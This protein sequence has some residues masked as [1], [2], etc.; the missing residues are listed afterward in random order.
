MLVTA[1]AIFVVVE[2]ARGDRAWAH[3]KRELERKGERLDFASFQPKSVPPDENFLKEPALALLLYK[4]S[5]DS[6]RQQLL[7]DTRLLE[8]DALG[9]Y[10][11]KNLSGVRDDLVRAGLLKRTP[12]NAPASDVLDALQP[13]NPLLDV[14]VEA[15]RLR[16]L[17]AF[18]PRPAPLEGPQLEVDLI[19][20]VSVA[21]SVR[22]AVYLELGRIHHAESDISAVQRLGNAFSDNPET[23]LNLLVGVSAQGLAAGAVLDG[24]RRHCWTEAQ[25]LVFERS[26]NQVKPLAG[27][28]HAMQAERAQV[29]YIIDLRPSLRANNFFWPWWMFH[30]WAQQNKIVYCQELQ[31]RVFNRFSGNLD[32]ITR[33]QLLGSAAPSGFPLYGW[34]SRLALSNYEKVLDGFGKSV[35]TLRLTTL[36]C[37]ME[38]H[39]LARGSV[40]DQ[41]D[42]LVPAFLPALPLGIVDGQRPRYRSNGNAHQVYYLGQNGR[43]DA[44]ADD[45]HALN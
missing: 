15:A 6:E 21:L 36:V 40:P 14:V 9:R 44:G 8:F 23:L 16:P 26:F 33:P 28:S 27:F 34:V 17:A 20:K 42:E 22:A 2:N 29:L 12:S 32:R 5:H 38:R 7:K 39:R 25:L 4:N 35:D 24:S 31:T 43:D 11:S 3:Y 1:L 41:L 45:D 19:Y 13:L 30:G 10:P 18:D 37:A